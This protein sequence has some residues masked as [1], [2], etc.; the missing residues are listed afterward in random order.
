[1]DINEEIGNIITQFKDMEYYLNCIITNF[2]SPKEAPFFEN[3]ILNS[4]ITS[5][6]NK[7]KVIKTICDHKGEKYNF[8]RLHQLLNL[9][10]LFAHENYYAEASKKGTLTKI[11]IFNPNAKFGKKYNTSKL[12]YKLKEFNEAYRIEIKNIMELNER[13]NKK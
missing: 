7:L 10:N 12:Q 9:R 13:L 1:M 2:I 8:D 11:D 3:I 4:N 6:G 5:T